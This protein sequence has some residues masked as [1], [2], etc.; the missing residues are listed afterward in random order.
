VLVQDL[1]D[2]PRVDVVAA[3]D[4]QVLLAVDDG[5]VAVLVDP[6]DVAGAEPPVGDRLGRL[7]G[8][9]PVALHQVVAADRDLADLALGNLGALVVDD[10]HLHPPDRRADRTRL[11]LPVGVVEGGHR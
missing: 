1:L 4:D 5:E 6:A 2:L 3:A 7:L 11:A 10:P 8:A 9:P